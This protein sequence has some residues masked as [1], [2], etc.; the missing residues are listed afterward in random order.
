M[1]PKRAPL[2]RLRYNYL[3][4]QFLEGASLPSAAV[5]PSDFGPHIGFVQLVEDLLPKQTP[6]YHLLML[7]RATV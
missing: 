1:K 7:T 5:P 6:K 2:C 4:W 3:E